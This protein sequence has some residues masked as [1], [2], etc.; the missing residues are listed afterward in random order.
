MCTKPQADCGQCPR[1]AHAGTAGTAVNSAA[2][3]G[4][5]P[6]CAGQGLSQ[7]HKWF[8]IARP[9]NLSH[10]QSHQAAQACI[11]APQSHL[12]NCQGV[13]VP[14]RSAQKA[15]GSFGVNPWDA[16]PPLRLTNPESHS[17]VLRAEQGEGDGPPSASPL[18]PEQT[19]VICKL[20]RPGWGPEN[21]RPEA[22]V[23]E[24]S[25]KQPGPKTP[26]PQGR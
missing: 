18:L 26:L 16:T 4:S 6:R 24:A 10:F 22:T 12:S 8:E 7:A 13:R 2:P 21:S 3:Q 5:E 11:R 14:A 17:S 15:S 23:S 20:A 25:W 19:Q 1:A 9:F